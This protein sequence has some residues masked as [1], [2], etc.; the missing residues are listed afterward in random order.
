MSQEPSIP[1]ILAGDDRMCKHQPSHQHVIDDNM[2]CFGW[3]HHPGTIKWHQLLAENIAQVDENETD[4]SYSDLAKLGKVNAFFVFL[5]QNDQP[6][7]S[8]S[9]GTWFEATRAEIRDRSRQ[10][11]AN[12]N[13][14][15]VVRDLKAFPVHHL[16][17]SDSGGSNFII[18][19]RKPFYPI[20]DKTVCFGWHQLFGTGWW[21]EIVL[22]LY[23]VYKKW[24]Q[25]IYL[26][27]R[28]QL[29]KEGFA[30][31][32]VFLDSNSMQTKMIQDGLWYQATEQEITV[33]SKQHFDEICKKGFGL[34]RWGG[35]T[36]CFGWYQLP[37][38]TRWHE[39]ILG[40]FLIYQE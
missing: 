7:K 15:T 31:F 11:T 27:I 21:H 23:L 32:L 17:H 9:D 36:V 4:T 29:T 35:T 12:I 39:T 20:H 18:G 3:D 25:T 28:K 24:D 26:Q 2:V 6:C 16:L 33:Q 5:D 8:I 40:L 1:T 38:T 13:N 19:A 22:G 34:D 14:P 10:H 30:I 37:G